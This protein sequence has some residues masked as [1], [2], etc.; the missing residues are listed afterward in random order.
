MRA[1]WSFWSKPWRARTGGTW[2]T[3]RHHLL[4]WI[5]SFEAARKHYPD[6]ELITDDEGAQLLIDRL[7][8]AFSRVSTSLNRLA[9]HDP[10]RWILGKLYAY[11]EQSEPF[12][13]L[14]T[15]VFLWKK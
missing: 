4:G 13:H 10:R 11:R 5:L 12:V 14:D 1:V 8:L 7:G 15:D 2:R 3:E 9:A 6:T